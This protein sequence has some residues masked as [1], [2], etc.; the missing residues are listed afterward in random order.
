MEGDLAVRF[1]VW[2]K[3]IKKGTKVTAAFVLNTHIS[4]GRFEDQFFV[5][6]LAEERYREVFLYVAAGPGKS[7]ER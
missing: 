7:Q 3:A 2:V 5:H 1:V 4:G 6:Q